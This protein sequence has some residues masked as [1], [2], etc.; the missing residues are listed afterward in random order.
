MLQSFRIKINVL[1]RKQNLHKYKLEMLLKILINKFTLTQ[2]I[3]AS[4]NR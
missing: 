4:L 3:H 1:I 2:T